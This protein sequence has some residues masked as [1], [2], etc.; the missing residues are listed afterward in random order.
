[1]TCLEAAKAADAGKGVFF[2]LGIYAGDVMNFQLA[3][4]LA[5]AQGI[6]VLQSISTDE[7]SSAPKGEEER[8]RGKP[9]KGSIVFSIAPDSQRNNLIGIAQKLFKNPL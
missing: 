9:P 8:R 2:L 7:V 3:A 5:K 1:M 4:D 6:K